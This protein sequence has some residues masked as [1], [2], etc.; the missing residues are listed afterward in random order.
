MP[1]S[2]PDDDNASARYLATFLYQKFGT[3]LVGWNYEQVLYCLSEH[4]LYLAIKEFYDT[5]P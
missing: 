3:T 5:L 2:S 4:E 1:S